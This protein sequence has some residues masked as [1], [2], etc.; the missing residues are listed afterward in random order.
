M[1]KD[2]DNV[3]IEEITGSH[4]LVLVTSGADA[5]VATVIPLRGGGVAIT[6]VD[7]TEIFANSPSMDVAARHFIEHCI[8]QL[9]T[10]SKP[11]ALINAV[12]LIG[13]HQK[14][15]NPIHI[16]YPATKCDEQRWQRMGVSTS[17]FPYVPMSEDRDLISDRSLV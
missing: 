17:S 8:Q 10:S 2:I 11:G 6:H 9:H 15:I 12:H 16:E 5:C 3:S 1:T 14:S 7:P 13:G 4:P